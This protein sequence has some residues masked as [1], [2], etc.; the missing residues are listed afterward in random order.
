[1]P[2]PTARK[3]VPMAAVVLPLPGPVFTMIRPRRTSLIFH[4]GLRSHLRLHVAWTSGARCSILL[5]PAG[6]LLAI[7]RGAFVKILVFSGSLVFWLWGRSQRP[8]AGAA[9]AG[10][11]AR[12]TLAF[13]TSRP[14]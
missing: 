13:H 10:R 9:V 11:S 5:E 4:F 8:A 6:M 3:A 12:P 7:F 14:R 1:M 2:C